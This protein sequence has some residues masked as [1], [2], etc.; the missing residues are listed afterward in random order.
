MKGYKFIGYVKS[1]K[2]NQID[3]IY[4]NPWLGGKFKC[5][6]KEG[7]ER[8]L[9]KKQ[10]V[11]LHEK[12]LIKCNFVELISA[13]KVTTGILVSIY[14]ALQSIK[15]RNILGDIPT[16]TKE[17]IWEENILKEDRDIDKFIEYCSKYIDSNN[18]FTEEQK[19]YLKI[20]WGRYLKDEGENL[21]FRT[22]INLYND[23]SNVEV[24]DTPY[25]NGFV[26][27]YKDELNK[28]FL[29]KDYEYK[30]ET[31]FHE[32]IH[33]FLRDNGIH[34]MTALD[35]GFSA[36]LE[37]K[38]CGETPLSYPEEN[39]YLLLIS[40]IIGKE[41]LTYLLEN[42]REDEFYSYLAECTNNS[43]IHVK[44]LIELTKTKIWYRQNQKYEKAEELDKEIKM[45]LASWA[46]QVN[47]KNQENF[48]ILNAMNSK[49][50]LDSSF[51]EENYFYWDT[52]NAFN[53]Y[54]IDDEN[55]YEYTYLFEENQTL[56]K[57]HNK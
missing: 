14:G 18:E 40:E 11:Y 2:Y 29:L 27:V 19:E 46:I 33:R 8:K 36:A 45:T 9:N 51:L 52:E 5:I 13:L 16:I 4:Y 17:F 50:R 34:I 37:K 48:I 15:Y 32:T 6:D 57:M 55:K 12:F 44:E 7:K 3:K 21:E 25:L 39:E 47:S 42:K 31:L 20:A 38:Y 54:I 26:G 56:A 53:F 23:L 10:R 35:E 30:N 1:T 28:I 49:Y 24:E 41:K 43:K 22:M